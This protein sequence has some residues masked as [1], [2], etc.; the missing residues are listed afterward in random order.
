MC[1]QRE[2]DWRLLPLEMDD[3]LMLTE[4]SQE[5]FLWHWNKY[6]WFITRDLGAST[7]SLLYSC[8][9]AWMIVVPELGR[10]LRMDALLQNQP[11]YAP[12]WKS[13]KRSSS[14]ASVP[15]SLLP[16]LFSGL[17][18]LKTYVFESAKSAWW[19]KRD[20]EKRNTGLNKPLSLLVS[21]TLSGSST[22]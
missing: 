20:A 15:P 21:P 18:R 8:C 22:Q 9:C 6:M 3:T 10:I 2:K 5:I 7:R 16:I 11:F 14:L 12:G 1:L 17:S 13:R 4:G 19:A